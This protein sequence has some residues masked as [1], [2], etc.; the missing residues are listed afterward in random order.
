M[1]FPNWF[2]ALRYNSTRSRQARRKKPRRPRLL[3]EYLEDRTT[4]TIIFSPHFGAEATTFG[5]GE[6]LNSAP[7]FLIF[8]GSYWNSSSANPSESAIQSAFTTELASPIFNR[9]TQYGSNG[10]AHF[11][12]SWIDTAVGDPGGPPPPGT[13]G[14]PSVSDSQ[15]QNVILN[16]INDPSSPIL[17]PSQFSTPP[18]YVVI[19]PPGITSSTYPPPAAGYHQDFSG[20]INAGKGTN[21]GSADIV[22]S[23]IE[24]FNISDPRAAMDLL[25]MTMS[26]ET[27]EAMTD[28]QV[29]TGITVSA[30]SN[31]PGG[32][33][34][35]ATGEIGDFE[36]DFTYTYRVDG[37]LT[38]ALWDY[39]DQAFVVN[40]GTTQNFYITP[41]WDSISGHFSFAGGALNLLGGGT[42]GS[43]YD[44]LI[45]IDVNSSGGVLVNMNGEIA[46]FDSG[47]ITSI[48][49]N[50]EGTGYNTINVYNTNVPVNINTGSGA[51][52][53]DTINI[54]NAFDGVQGIDFPGQVTVA[55]VVPPPP[56]GASPPPTVTLNI[57]DSA[58][59]VRQESCFISN[60]EVILGHGEIFFDESQLAPLSTNGGTSLNIYGGSGGNDFTVLSTPQNSVG[61]STYLNAGAGS[62][63]VRVLT[64]NGSLYVDAGQGGGNVII[65]TLDPYPTLIGD[66]A[67]INGFV[68]V[69][70]AASLDVNDAK[71]TTGRSATLTSYGSLIGLAPAPITYGNDVSSVAIQ[72]GS[73]NNAITVAGT[74]GG[75]PVTLFDYFGY[76]SV[77]V[78]STSGPLYVDGGCGAQTVT[79][80]NLAPSL[81]GPLA[82]INGL[83]DVYNTCSGGGGIGLQTFN[84]DAGADSVASGF[85]QVIVDDS[86]DPIGRSATLA[87]NS[88]TGL[89]PA[90][91]E[92]GPTVSGLTID[93]GSGTNT[94]TVDL[95]NLATPFVT[96]ADS[97]P[98]TDGDTLN[99]EVASG[100]NTMVKTATS[101]TWGS[102]VT[103]TIN[104][105]GIEYLI[106][107]GQ[108]GTYNTITDPGSQNTTIIGGPGVNNIFLANTVGNGVVFQDGGG[109]N[110]ITVTMGNLLG[111][112]TLNGTTGTTQVTVVAPAGNNVLTLSATQLTGAGETIN[113]NLGT[114]LTSL[115]IDGSAG[116]NQLVVQGSPPGPLTLVNVIV[117]TST[118]VVPSVDPSV[119]NQ[120][121]TFT[122]TVSP[123]V[124]AA[125]PP[126]GSA[127]FQVDGVNFGSPV[128]LS[129]GVATLTTSALALGPHTITALY[130]GAT[131]F[132]ASSGSVVQYVQYNFS[133]FL[134]PLNHNLAF[135]IGR[136]VPI[137]FQLSDALGNYISSISAVT[138]L[139]ALNSQGTNVLTNA[140]STALR[141]DSTAN[142]FIANWQTKWLPA[143]T[144]TVTLALADGSTHTKT[145]QLAAN[146]SNAGLVVDGTS[147]TAVD[148]ALLAGDVELYVDN[149]SGLLT[150]DELARIDS[151]VAEV[152]SV[153]A[154]YGVTISETRDSG[155]ANVV[156]DMGST[157]AVG[158]YADGV[159]GCYTGDTGEITLIQGWNWY[160]G[161]DATQVGRG[162]YDFETV[163]THELGHALGLGHS[164]DSGSTM[165]Y[166]LDAG[167]AKRTLATADLNVADDGGGPDGLHAVGASA[168]ASQNPLDGASGVTNAF[169]APV[170]AAF[171]APQRFS[172]ESAL[173]VILAG[174]HDVGSF[175]SPY[176]G[177]VLASAQAPAATQSLGGWAGQAYGFTV[178][179]DGLV[180]DSFNVSSNGPAFG[181]ANNTARNLHDL[182][183]AVHQQAVDGVLHEG[184]TCL[185]KEA[186]DLFDALNKAGAIS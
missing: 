100:R 121:V 47:A 106:V 64:T 108:R 40:D 181:V 182:L 4:P 155:L 72:T 171:L 178:S 37:V 16:A 45:S 22:Y 124:A 149:S 185:S 107:N 176:L 151:A 135:A 39:N 12:A 160:A 179:A 97:G 38:Q 88:L 113:F 119:L 6:M 138:S 153:I 26:H 147:A 71:D 11:E 86:G 59:T 125:G 17:A 127:Q 41:L 5:T 162:Q 165:Y 31:W 48:N 57:N 150:S 43:A 148:G 80:G 111:P 103:E 141:Y 157:S 94:Y 156:L 42:F 8:W 9:L 167:S 65:G 85:S 129:G 32:A 110:A 91:I 95:G 123:A 78:E 62:N 20:N 169:A 186:N 53:H 49:V 117:A 98:S 139:Q 166:E 23:W 116:N 74:Y 29:P 82:T 136:T 143:G 30:G 161:A 133:G 15:I 102:P 159:L 58:D 118:S 109:T 164:K 51:G 146:G 81:G 67:N 152:E 132:L 34:G 77:N 140:G 92:Y 55:E 99:M 27:A 68:A 73:G 3:V 163:V 120:A 10:S 128:G 13:T 184:D 137:K 60:N 50:P 18:L 36:P 168:G 114:T 52:T 105:S 115:V 126:P 35:E 61:V 170:P 44:N 79:I 180:A 33:S 131:L 144:Y 2:Q 134:P 183:E 25:T 101:I 122:A 93:A 112:V 14:G 56:G 175:L 172:T 177:G 24:N 76:N 104:Y 130:G 145:V 21:A 142:Q 83:V 46:S 96:I 89:A 28:P 66:V 154:P 7:V 158:A 70:R 63:S 19:T 1:R 174:G 90:V 173:A 75:I 84:S 87:G 54:G 69:L